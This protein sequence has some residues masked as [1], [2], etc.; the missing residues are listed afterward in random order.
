MSQQDLLAVTQLPNKK[1]RDQDTFL[2]TQIGFF[3]TYTNRVSRGVR[4][5]VCFPSGQAISAVTS[6]SALFSST[7][8]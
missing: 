2:I 8:A 4:V 7:R 6:S 3:Y 5:N 1:V